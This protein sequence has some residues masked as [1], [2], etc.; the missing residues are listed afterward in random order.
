MSDEKITNEALFPIHGPYI[1]EDIRDNESVTAMVTLMDSGRMVTREFRVWRMSPLGIEFLLKADTTLAKGSQIGV[2]INLGNQ[3]SSLKGLVVDDVGYEGKRRIAYVRLVTKFEDSQVATE[4]REASRWICSSEFYPTGIAPNPVRFNDFIYFKVADISYGGMKLTA[5]LRNKFLISGITIEAVLNFPMGSQINMRLRINNVRIENQNGKDVLAIG[6]TYDTANIMANKLIA[7]YLLQ[8]S[9]V[10]SLADIRQAGFVAGAISESVTFAYVRTKEEFEEVL[11]LRFE[12]YK[13]AGKVADG[14]THM[15]MSDQFDAK[16]RIV[17]GKIK[18]EVICSARLTFHQLGDKLEQENYVHWSTDLPRQDE[19]VEIMRACTKPGFRGSDLL[20]GMFKFMAVTVAQTKKQWIV[21]CAT[22]EM[23]PFYEKVGFKKIGR[24][25]DHPALN[26]IHHH[27]M[28]ANFM[29]GMSGRSVG[30]IYW[31]IVWADSVD[32]M[33]QYDLI[34]VDPF[35]QIRLTAYRWM[36]P[37]AKFVANRKLA[38]K[39]LARISSDAKN[40][41]KIDDAA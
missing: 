7:N 1:P 34:N 31:N 38:R 4:R 14:K 30:P 40:V 32:Y 37:F 12:A 5:S 33:A 23:V 28:L 19:V 21:I 2:V 10:S 17:I 15:D 3:Q 35:M 36:R 18:G 20:A 39:P 11:K 27:V 24:S 26:N 13:A 16:S 25:Y 8:F 29:D 6:A 22:D 41:Q 9:S